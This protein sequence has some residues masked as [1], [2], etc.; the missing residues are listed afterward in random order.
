MAEPA[1]DLRIRAL[2]GGEEPALLAFLAQAF[3][4]RPGK[5]N[6]ALW[7][8]QF[9]RSP[10][11]SPGEYLTRVCWDGGR[12]VGQ[13]ALT[14]FNLLVGTK[15][16]PAN[17]G[18]DLVVHPDVRGRGIGPKLVQS[19]A[20]MDRLHVGI[21]FTDTA[22]HL[23]DRAGATRLPGVRRFAYV[24]RP[25]LVVRRLSRLRVIRSLL[26]TAGG[27]A[28]AAHHLFI[29][30]HTLRGVSVDVLSRFDPEV[31]E[32][33]RRD[34]TG[35]LVVAERSSQLLNWRFSE[36]PGAPYRILAAR[37]GRTLVG[38][39]VGYES[40]PGRY[41]IADIWAQGL[42]QDVLGMLV[43]EL[44]S[45]NQA[46]PD[47]QVTECYATHP[48]LTAVLVSRGFLGLGGTNIAVH[49][50]TSGLDGGVL[51]RSRDWYVTAFDGDF[52]PI[53]RF[54]TIP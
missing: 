54:A 16:Y 50:A 30:R 1:S 10:L 18:A 41:L 13:F 36:A 45:R 20:A 31:D 2:Q 14:P 34:D 7:Q 4:E 52:D 26:R 21:G 42:R 33:F 35:T 32:L 17:W 51:R 3:K 19:L 27:A 44:V 25:D 37:R 49:P 8:W 39:A 38:Y 47:C 12:I 6:P 46:Q 15:R 48:A 11:L 53:F 40:R 28:I 29:R 9:A 5:S 23:Y 43:A 24:H 22:A